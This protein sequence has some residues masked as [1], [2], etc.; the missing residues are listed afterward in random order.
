M[1]LNDFPR[2]VAQGVCLQVLD[3]AQSTN[4]V[5]IDNPGPDDSWTVV[6][7]DDQ[8]AGRGR[9]DRKWL[10]LPGRGL[11]V[12]IQLP[13][14]VTPHPIHRGWLGWLALIVGAA[15]ADVV[16]TVSISNVSVKWPNDVLIGGKKVAGILGEISP[17]S[18]VV[19]G[20]GINL[21]YKEHELPTP[22]ST[23]LSIHQ[24]L[25][26]DIADQLVAQVLEKL[27]CVMPQVS[28]G[29]PAGIREW[30]EGR[31]GTLNGAVR[32]TTPAGDTLVG[33]ASGLA[34]DGSLRIAL[35]ESGSEVRVSV[36]EI[37][38]LRHV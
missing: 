17:N 30:V 36:G 4:R 8:T 26:T 32:V 23:S 25:A 21:F 12:S 20:I 3:T 1:T 33:V 9:S 7:T 34:D 38:H 37:E 19:V 5:L 29:I 31:L 35:E 10:S 2:V 11:A 6:I 28:K 14:S 18:R 24:T 22:D 15:L 13:T 16:A 27:I